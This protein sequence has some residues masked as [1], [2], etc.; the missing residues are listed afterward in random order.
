MSPF[1]KNEIWAFLTKVL[2]N[3]VE[4]SRNFTVLNSRNFSIFWKILE[5][6]I[7]EIL[8]LQSGNIL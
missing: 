1:S 2:G 7:S 4:N 5:M 8:L 6:N 3:F